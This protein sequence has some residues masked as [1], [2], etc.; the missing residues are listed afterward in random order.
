MPSEQMTAQRFVV[1]SSA[2]SGSNMLRSL[3]EE[4]PD[5]ACSGEMFNPANGD[6][7]VKWARKSAVRR[8]QNRY[9]RNHCV[10]AYL[11]NLFAKAYLQGAPKAIG[12]KVM[13][14]GQFNR[15]SIFPYYWQEHGFKIVRLTR[16]NLLRRYVSSKI[17]N[18]EDVWATREHRGTRVTLKVEIDDLL[19]RL[20]RME[21]IN[22]R[23]NSLV[24]EFDHIMV[25]YERLVADKGAVMQAVF[26]FLGVGGGDRSHDVQAKT[27]RQ[28]PD[29]LSDLIENYDEVCTALQATPWRRF[30]EEQTS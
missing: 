8:L 3:L 29:R 24:N 16:H 5:V 10:E 6:G 21:V 11:D 2:R 17:A 27:V 22:Q 14:P 25:D 7:Y 18:L 12:F 26:G 20:S 1:L 15:C 30:I 23:I 28:N 9:L 13:Y 4:H 19:A